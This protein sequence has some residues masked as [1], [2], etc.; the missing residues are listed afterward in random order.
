METTQPFQSALYS[1]NTRKMDRSNETQTPFNQAVTSN[2][3]ATGHAIE[4][5]TPETTGMNDVEAHSN[6]SQSTNGGEVASSMNP[7]GHAS[8]STPLSPTSMNTSPHNNLPESSN[9]VQ[10]PRSNSVSASSD[11]STE[12]HFPASMT[13]QAVNAPG[14][15]GVIGENIMGALGYGGSAVEWPK[16]DQG[17]G[18]KVAEFLGA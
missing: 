11:P 4:P 15:T 7:I 17:I 6:L 2:S 12:T 16:E 10:V 9:V 13:G 3:N 1:Y 14:K 5:V 8:S 18:E